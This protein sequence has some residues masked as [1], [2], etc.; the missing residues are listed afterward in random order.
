MQSWV[1][2]L[3]WV[4]RVS[5]EYL[6]VHPL[7]EQIVIRSKEPTLRYIIITLYTVK[8]SSLILYHI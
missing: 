6:N 3:L 4:K 7:S 5:L 8:S 2:L 1:F